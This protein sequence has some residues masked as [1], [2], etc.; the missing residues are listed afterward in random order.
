MSRVEGLIGAEYEDSD[1]RRYVKR[2][3]TEKGHLFTFLT[4]FVDYHSSISERGLRIFAEFRKILYGSRSE[5]GAE[6]TK[7]MMSVYAMCRMRGM[8]FYQF[9]RDFL[10]GKV[11]A[12]PAGKIVRAAAAAAA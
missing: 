4:D 12:I 6:R 8:N 5:R 2:L 1:C 10:E 11:A 9:T 3:R 7:I